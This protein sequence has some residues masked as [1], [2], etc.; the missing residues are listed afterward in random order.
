M[1]S[2]RKEAYPEGYDNYARAADSER[3]KD[4]PSDQR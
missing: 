4:P 3:K 1:R 2:E